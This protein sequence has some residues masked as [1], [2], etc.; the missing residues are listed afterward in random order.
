MIRPA[1]P[2]HTA[3]SVPVKGRFEARSLGLHPALSPEAATGR[4]SS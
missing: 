4:R 2:Y 3:A 1:S